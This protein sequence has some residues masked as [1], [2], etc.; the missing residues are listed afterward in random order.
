MASILGFPSYNR[1]ILEPNGSN[2]CLVYQMERVGNNLIFGQGQDQ[3]DHL[4][5]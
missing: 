4:C 5:F 3:G 2:V 1:P